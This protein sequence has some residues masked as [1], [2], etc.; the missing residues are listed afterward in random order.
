MVLHDSESGR[1]RA[2]R[3]VSIF[4]VAPFCLQQQGN[5]HRV[6]NTCPRYWSG[7]RGTLASRR[8]AR[9]G[10]SASPTGLNYRA[11]AKEVAMSQ[12]LV[13]HEVIERIAVLTLN[14]PE[15]RNA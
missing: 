6:P 13:L 2:L 9:R 12:S 1:G 7:R 3:R 11:D 8:Q 5:Y 4:H 10:K 14:H 15:K